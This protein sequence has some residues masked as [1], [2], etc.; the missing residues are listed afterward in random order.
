MVTWLYDF[1]FFIC[2]F[3]YIRVY[4]WTLNLKHIKN[5]VHILVT[6]FNNNVSALRRQ[7]V[8]KIN[9]IQNSKIHVKIKSNIIFFNTEKI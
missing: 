8:S 9:T 6:V 5:N 2:I 1:K 3:I 7:L 4:I